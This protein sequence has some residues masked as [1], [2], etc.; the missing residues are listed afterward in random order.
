MSSNTV[1]MSL[2][3]TGQKCERPGRNSLPGSQAFWF[4]LR[5]LLYW[6]KVMTP[7]VPLP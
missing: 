4:Y 3:T 5:N 1:T 7:K 6:P 2:L